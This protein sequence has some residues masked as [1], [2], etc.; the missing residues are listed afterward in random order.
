M[1]PLAARDEL[2]TPTVATSEFLVQ[3]RNRR[4]VE[5]GENPPCT[6]TPAGTTADAPSPVMTPPR[7]ERYTVRHT[8]TRVWETSVTAKTAERAERK[9]SG[10]TRGWTYVSDDV[11][12]EATAMPHKTRARPSKPTAVAEP[13][14]RTRPERV[15]QHMI[16]PAP[17]HSNP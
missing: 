8:Q 11:V 7:T 15:A 2:T 5:L 9:A 17:A 1:P 13:A 6:R 16:G 10:L 12:L 14:R 3:Q 4:S